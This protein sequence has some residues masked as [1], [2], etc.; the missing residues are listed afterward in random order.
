MPTDRRPRNIVPSI[1]MSRPQG[2]GSRSAVLTK[3]LPGTHNRILAIATDLF[4]RRGYTR[5][6]IREIIKAAGVTRPVLYYHFGN[7]EGLYRASVASCEHQVERLLEEVKQAASPPREKIE[8]LCIGLCLLMQGFPHLLHVIRE[9]A[10][11]SDQDM[12]TR[13][14][15]SIRARI[16]TSFH[17]LVEEGRRAGKFRF[18]QAE[19]AVSLLMGLI[20]A[21][22][23]CE[24]T[25]IGRSRRLAAFER[26]LQL[27]FEGISIRQN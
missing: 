25:Q 15:L 23:T 2:N 18:A 6:S 21:T 8:Q 12:P 17:A 20:Y 9:D 14:I 16:E 10:L 7:K 4:G 24:T 11:G 27:A 26:S 5:T 19:D 22:E 1:P 13:P 3:S